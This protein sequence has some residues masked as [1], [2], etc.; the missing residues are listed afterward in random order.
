MQNTYQLTRLLG[1]HLDEISHSHGTD[2]PCP[3]AIS[4][5][6]ISCPRLS[7]CKIQ[8]YLR[9]LK[10]SVVLLL[11]VSTSFMDLLFQFTYKTVTIIC[12]VI[13]IFEKQQSWHLLEVSKNSHQFSFICVNS[14][15]IKNN[16]IQDPKFMTNYYL[17][18]K[19]WHKCAQSNSNPH[20]AARASIIR[21]LLPTQ[22]VSLSY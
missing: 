22:C 8:T 15:S 13:F 1:K 6:I 11:K 14:K 10:H 20:T 17:F 16:H 3:L 9:F 4:R 5:N 2:H 12:H 19:S 21:I 18:S 7:L